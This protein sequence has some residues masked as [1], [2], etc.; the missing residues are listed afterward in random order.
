MFFMNGRKNYSATIYDSQY[1]AIVEELVDLRISADLKQGDVAKA[2][3]LTQPDI[4]KIERFERR[5]DALELA[6]W[7]KVTDG[8]FDKIL[9]KILD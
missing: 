9:N 2:L 8:S 5:I 1:K 3:G 6:R 7:L 4:S